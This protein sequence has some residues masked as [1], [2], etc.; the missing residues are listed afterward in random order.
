MQAYPPRKGDEYDRSV[1]YEMMIKGLD[2]LPLWAL[3]A[4]FNTYLKTSKWRPTVAD[5][6]ELALKELNPLKKAVEA[7]QRAIKEWE[8]KNGKSE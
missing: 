8:A 4:A 1:M 3:G 2:D 6:R 7:I 5:L